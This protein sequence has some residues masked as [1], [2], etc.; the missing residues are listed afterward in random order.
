LNAQGCG[1]MLFHDTKSAAATILPPFLKEQKDQGYHEVPVRAPTARCTQCRHRK[2]RNELLSLI[3]RYLA[4]VHLGGLTATPAVM[5]P[6][7]S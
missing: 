6:P 5:M 3:S 7:L 4:S 2:G 1:I